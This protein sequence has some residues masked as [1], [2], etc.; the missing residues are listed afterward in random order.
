MNHGGVV[1]K[2][3]VPKRFDEVSKKINLLNQGVVL[4]YSDNDIE[5]KDV[6]NAAQSLVVD[7]IE[8]RVIKAW[9]DQPIKANNSDEFYI[10]FLR[11]NYGYV[12]QIE[13]DAWNSLLQEVIN[14]DLDL[15][16]FSPL[17][18]AV[19]TLV[20]FGFEFSPISSRE[21]YIEIGKYSQLYE[22]LLKNKLKD[23]YRAETL[24]GL[25][26]KN[27]PSL[28]LRIIALD[29]LIL[30]MFRN[31]IIDVEEGEMTSGYAYEKISQK[32][33]DL[34]DACILKFKP[35]VINFLKKAALDNNLTESSPDYNH[36]NHRTHSR[37]CPFLRAQSKRE[38]LNHGIAVFIKQHRRFC[39]NLIF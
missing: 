9:I 20:S 27:L 13:I 30:R 38:V 11:V 19:F 31:E 23:N 15:D 34:D 2:D 28:L 8:S 33:F 36:R 6:T 22:S 3:P 37:G 5:N 10:E 21:L 24:Y 39:L 4:L 14:Q 26:E 7:E 32:C 17:Q 25:L 18:A 12:N 35:S 16:N 1:Y 29:P